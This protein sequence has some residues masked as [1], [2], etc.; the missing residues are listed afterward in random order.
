MASRS[1]L[2][3]NIVRKA[4]VLIIISLCIFSIPLLADPSDGGSENLIRIYEV[5][6]Y[7]DEGFSL[8]NYGSTDVDLCGM[9][10]TD[11]EGTISFTKSLIV[12]PRSRLTVVIGDADDNWFSS[13]DCVFRINTNGITKTGSFILNNSGDEVI[14][15]SDS[16][17]IDS[18]CY[19]NKTI[20]LGWSGAPVP[21]S[22]NSYILRTGILD[23]DTSNDWIKTKPGLTNREFNPDD[24]MD[25]IV[26]PFT[27]PES[28]GIPIYRAIEQA[29][30][31]VLISIY[32][33]T[34]KN[35]VGLLI[36]LEERTGDEHVDVKIIIEGDPLNYDMSTELSLMG[37][38]VMSGGEVWTIN[39]PE[40]GNYERF[41]FFHNKYA[42]IDRE[43]VIITSENWTTD[44]MSGSRYANRGWGVMIESDQYARYMADIWENDH[45]ASYGD[46]APLMERF[47]DLKPYP[48][49]LS[50]T[51]PTKEYEMYR[52]QSKVVPVLSPDNSYDALKEL[53]EGSDH[54]ISSEQLDLGNSY[55]KIN[56]DSPISWM[57][58]AANRGVQCK[59][60]LDGSIDDVSPMINMINTT[61]DVEAC[62]IDGG[63]GFR[64]THNK[65]V[66]I[67]GNITWIGSVNWTE[68]SFLDNRETAVVI[69]STEINEFFTGYFMKDWKDN[70]TTDF[71]DLEITVEKGTSDFEGF[72]IFTVDAP[73][74]LTYI[75]SLD[76]GEPI[77]TDIP[78][79][80]LNGLSPGEHKMKVRV[81]DTINTTYCSFVV[82][83]AQAGSDNDLL[84][85]GKGLLAGISAVAI[86]I[87]GTLVA[88]KRRNG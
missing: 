56:D 32:Q 24:P 79:L 16:T 42:I 66:L 14:L 47:P 12:A 6:P 63:N 82:S 86:A 39:T 61:T 29:D 48:G 62:S 35:L 9:K 87:V 88:I 60:I 2:G 49:D 30:D 3:S 27:F 52:Y 77:T 80:A 33:L 36:D 8:Y 53:M 58:D 34:S 11:G 59:F 38:I 50:Y 20:A 31:E 7:G 64:T 75:W 13:R 22:S 65:G 28:E 21:I 37:S 17:F 70:N 78:K 85:D 44:N 73:G 26:M 43:N 18:V 54:S 72:Y 67:D 10:V 40:S 74:S 23:T 81:Q 41:S 57:N 1:M 19:G 25:C 71:D 45:D 55:S 5:D 15:S 51:S 4:S 84:S 46:A 76:D 83:D 68:T 69:Y